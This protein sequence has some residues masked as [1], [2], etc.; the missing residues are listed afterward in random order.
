MS[1]GLGTK[2][3]VLLGPAILLIAAFLAAP[4][5]LTAILLAAIMLTPIL[6]A[7]ILLA[8]IMLAGFVLTPVLLAVRLGALRLGLALVVRG[9]F[10]AAFARAI[11][12]AGSTPEVLA[13]IAFGTIAA[14][15][16]AAILLLL[17][18]LSCRDDAVVMLGMLQIAFRDD[19]VARRRRI[20]R[21][22]QILFVDLEGAATNTNIG[23]IRVERLHA[24]RHVRATSAVIVVVI[25][26]IVVIT[27][28]RPFG[29]GTLSHPEYL[30]S[31]PVS[32]TR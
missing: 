5:L 1:L 2:S 23:A 29:V 14:V 13:I 19:A 21:K 28:A 7:P 11:L 8:S 10:I 18:F 3:R 32:A 24:Q 20:T 15:R 9:K 26:I 12:T 25:V 27:P 31:L 30:L 4:I 6:L 22:L 17:L 16:V